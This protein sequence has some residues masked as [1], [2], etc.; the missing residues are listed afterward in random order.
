MILIAKLTKTV[1][2]LTTKLSKSIDLN[3]EYIGSKQTDYIYKHKKS[4]CII[5]EINIF[6]GD[7]FDL[8]S[9]E[10][11]YLRNYN[12]SVRMNDE[13]LNYKNKRS[14]K[15]NVIDLFSGVGGFSKGFQ[16]ANN[17][18]ILANEIDTSIAK[19]YKLNHPNTIMINEDIKILLRI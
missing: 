19:S 8:D 2:E 18:I 6:I 9:T 11:E 10:I 5:D 15:M 14:E 13:L 12:L 3:K 17:K 1:K 4:K 7:L 16:Q